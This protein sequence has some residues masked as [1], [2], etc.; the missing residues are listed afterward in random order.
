VRSLAE[1]V[2]AEIASRVRPGQD[3]SA[4]VVDRVAEAADYR[5]GDVVVLHRETGSGSP[6][7]RVGVYCQA[8]YGTCRYA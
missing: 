1:Y 5:A 6:P 7:A 4:V 2:R 3:T 8:R